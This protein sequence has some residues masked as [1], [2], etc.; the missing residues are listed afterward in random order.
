VTESSCIKILLGTINIL[1]Q[2]YF[3]LFDAGAEFLFWP[4]N[5][6]AV[7]ELQSDPIL[8]KLTVIQ[9]EFERNP[10]LF[11]GQIL[12]LGCVNILCTQYKTAYPLFKGFNPL[13]KLCRQSCHNTDT[14]GGSVW[15]YNH[16]CN[17]TFNKWLSVHS[18][19]RILF[20]YK[21]AWFITL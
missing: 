14:K 10:W 8:W 3:M 21:K 2:I 16:P 11:E 4:Q 13:W 20:F 7:H 5:R 12:N 1:D 18:V 19:G 6:K 9:H 17:A 15:L